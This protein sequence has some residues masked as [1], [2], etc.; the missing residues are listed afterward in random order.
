MMGSCTFNSEL[1]TLFHQDKA[2]ILQYK[3][4]YQGPAN[5]KIIYNHVKKKI[6]IRLQGLL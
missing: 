2:H 3:F 6:F 5:W 4:G 1:T